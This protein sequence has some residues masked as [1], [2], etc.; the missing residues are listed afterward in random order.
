MLLPLFGCGGMVLIKEGKYPEAAAGNQAPPPTNSSIESCS[1]SI[2]GARSRVAAVAPP[3]DRR[4]RKNPRMVD[5]APGGAPGGGTALQCL[6]STGIVCSRKAGAVAGVAVDT[7]L[8]PLDTVKTRLQSRAGFAASG[9]FRGIY[10]G[11]ASAAFGAAPASASFFLAYEYF[12]AALTPVLGHDRAAVAHLLAAS[13][14]E[15]AACVVRV[16]TDVIKQRLQTN[17]YRTTLD[18]IRGTWSVD[19]PLGFYRAYFTTVLREVSRFEITRNPGGANC[20]VRAR[21]NGTAPFLKIPFACI[22]FPLYEMFKQTWGDRKKR[23]V[24]AGEAALCGSAAGGFAAAVTT[25]LDVVKTRMMLSTKVQSRGR[26]ALGRIPSRSL[27]TF[28]IFF[29]LSFALLTGKFPDR[30]LHLDGQGSVRGGAVGLVPG[31]RPARFVDQH[32]GL[33]FF[34]SVREIES[35]PRGALSAVYY[36]DACSRESCRLGLNYG[37]A[38]LVSLRPVSGAV[39]LPG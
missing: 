1:G 17:Q 23:T 27:G 8:F 7:F 39:W 19:G 35:R 33:D 14:G 32:R 36:G 30:R 6:A 2:R 31:S 15:V 16:P 9:G 37:G 10:S 25:P 13:A 11:L 5:P 34:G 26:G 29:F 12:K 4:K 21:C 38:R 28:C 24:T 18:A 22:Q 3:E 20:R